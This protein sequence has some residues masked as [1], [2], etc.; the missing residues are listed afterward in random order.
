[1]ITYDN[2]EV[3]PNNMVLN[4]EAV[5]I[6][7]E[8]KLLLVIKGV[9][10]LVTNIKSKD[11]FGLLK[12]DVVVTNSNGSE[13]NF[14]VY[15]YVDGVGVEKVP[16]TNLIIS[17]LSMF[18]T[19]AGSVLVMNESKKCFNLCNENDVY[20]FVSCSKNKFENLYR[21]SSITKGI[22]S[23]SNITVNVNKK[24]K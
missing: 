15:K 18:A 9:E 8:S 12:D 17:N 19:S 23:N 2:K 3:N 7:K 14:I 16:N 1:M 20:E 11:K 4:K 5:L 6:K 10:Y 13:T 22:L 21:I 24:E